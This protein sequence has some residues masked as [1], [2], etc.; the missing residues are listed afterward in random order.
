MRFGFLSILVALSTGS[1]YV[2]AQSQEAEAEND[3][4]PNTYVIRLDQGVSSSLTGRSTTNQHEQFHKRATAVDY[5]VRHEFKN[6]DVFFGLSITLGASAN[7]NDVNT[8]LDLPGVL[9]IEPVRLI[10]RP[11]GRV[12]NNTFIPEPSN[13]LT[14]ERISMPKVKGQTNGLLSALEMTGV[15]KL[16]SAGIKGKGIKIGIIDSGIDYRHPALGG[17]FGP[18]FKVEGGYAFVDDAGFA[19]TSEDPLTTCLLGGHGTHVAGLSNFPVLPPLLS[20]TY[21]SLK[22]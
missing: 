21:S 5:S 6:T 9:S 3:I 19:I 14:G 16:H 18:G 4:I 13:F 2:S 1:L 11:D 17:G 8:L 22:T 7:E 10:P 20:R 15:D 12:F